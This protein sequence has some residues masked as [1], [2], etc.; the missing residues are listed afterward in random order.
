MNFKQIQ[1]F[2]LSTVLAL[3]SCSQ[4]NATVEII[5]EEGQAETATSNISEPHEY[6]GWYCPDNLNGFPPVDVTDWNSVP[7]VNGRLPTAEETRNGTSL[8]LVDLD[9]YPAAKSLDMELPRL[10]RFY[11]VHTKKD[12]LVIIIQAIHVSNDYIVGFR[13]LN[14]GNG[15]AHLSDVRFLSSDEIDRISPSRFVSIDIPISSTQAEIWKVLTQ[16]DYG[17]ILQTIF[18]KENVLGE[19][20]TASSKVNYVYT[21]RGEV[22]A[23]YAENLFGN[24]YIQIDC[25]SEF[26]DYVEKF[27]LLENPETQ[28]TVL[29][30]ACGPYHEDYNQQKAILEEWAQKVKAL[31]ESRKL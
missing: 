27:L 26:G 20:W 28:I 25:K 19:G 14:G 22:A 10:A 1:T 5:P 16:P 11:N 13:Y 21:K 31:S 9:K 3:N 18:D 4:N 17:F 24:Q 23:Q 12:E 6:G 8:I 30:I 29:K 15:S 7:V 2:T